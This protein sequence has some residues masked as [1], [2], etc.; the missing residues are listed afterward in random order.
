MEKLTFSMENYL[1]AVYE[2][3]VMSGGTARVS[4][5]AARMGVS[6]ASVNNAM[7]VLAQ[8]GLLENEKYREICLTDEGR[9]VG[10][11]TAGKH[12][13]LLQLLRFLNVDE[14][15]ADEDACAIE[16]VISVASVQRIYDFLEKQGIDAL[17]ER[18]EPQ[19]QD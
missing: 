8:R 17:P 7:N 11:M 6:K 13:I 15:T 18:I 16:H 5:I 1:E 12:A 14:H 19:E 10:R 2:L 4:D 9:S 3:S